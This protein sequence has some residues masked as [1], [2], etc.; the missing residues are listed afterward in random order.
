MTVNGTLTPTEILAAL[1]GAGLDVY[2]MPGWRDRCRCH[3]GSHER[4]VGRRAA[5]GP[6]LGVMWHHTAGP[7]LGGQAAIDY[8]RNI[9][10]NGNGAT[11]G[12]LCLAGIDKDGRILLVGAGR[13]NHAG[14]MSAAA[15]DALRNGT[16]GTSGDRNLRG[17]GV[18]GNTITVGWEILA[19]HAP[20]STQ[21]QA[22]I[23]ATAAIL[24]ALGKPG[25]AIIGH[26]EASDQRDF[27]DPGLDMGAVRRDVTR[28][29]AD[30]AR[31]V[32]PVTPVQEDDDMPYTEQQLKAIIRDTM[33]EIMGGGYNAA[34]QK[35]LGDA[36][37]SERG[38]T[39]AAQAAQK[40]ISDWSRIPQALAAISA[41]VGAQVDEKTLAAAIVAGL[42]GEVRDA[43]RD[44][45]T[46]GGSPDAIADRVVARLGEA[47][48]QS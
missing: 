35:A 24:R 45:A 12:P 1:T 32:T 33:H 14:G 31:P 6:T 44:A 16:L 10:I 26:G 19:P 28:L 22:A 3:T 39:L 27:S 34:T 37:A 43:V 9:L 47:L 7:M 25:S 36:L 41:K 23:A 2:Q 13:A 4:S 48:T 20:N 40:A 30:P 5:F 11:V 29:L 42:T 38:H 18:D 21:R 8:T 15:R 46:Q 17:R